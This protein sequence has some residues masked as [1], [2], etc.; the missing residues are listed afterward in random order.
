MKRP[1]KPAGPPRW[2]PPSIAAMPAYQTRRR[3]RSVALV[4]PAHQTGRRPR[5]IAYGPAGQT[6]RAPASGTTEYEGRP[7]AALALVQVGMDL[8]PTILACPSRLFF[9]LTLRISPL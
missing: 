3:L 9:T 7:S 5:S 1:A 6:R 4:R 2:R 8:T